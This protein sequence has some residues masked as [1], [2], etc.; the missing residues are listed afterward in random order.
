VIE[1][2]GFGRGVRDFDDREL[3]VLYC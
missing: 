1:V 3:L 2:V